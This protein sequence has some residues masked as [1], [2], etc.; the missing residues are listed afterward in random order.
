MRRLALL[1]LVALA[2]PTAAFQIPARVSVTDGE[3][4]LADL[5]PDAPASWQ[6]VALGRAPR[7]GGE[8]TLSRE[9]ILQRARQVGAEGRIEVEGDVTLT[10]PGREVAREEIVRTVQEAL[11]G[12][13]GSGERMHVLTVGL[14]ASVPEGEL[15]L[16]AVVPEGALP[17]PATVWVDVLVDGERRGRGWV[18]V[19]VS[20]AVPVLT[21]SR[22]V[23]RGEVLT[24]RDLEVR[25]GAPRADALSDPSEALGK[26]MVR[27]RRAGTAL[28]ARDLES[29]PLVSRGDTVR[30]V[31]RVNGVSASTLGRALDTAGLGDHLVVENL[32]SGRT[33]T[34]ILREGGVVDAL[35]GREM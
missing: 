19:E 28:A 26:Q 23:R 35:P 3:V 4:S 27:S 1:L 7:P 18:R 6:N 34:G 33:V 24:A 20:R 11:S 5:T 17:S 13:L 32:S 12:R 10:R 16:S 21:L 22:D 29:V 9:W 2:S 25:A 14:P 31:A 15:S 8:R 30:V